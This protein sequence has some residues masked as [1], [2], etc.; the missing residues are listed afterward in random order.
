[1]VNGVGIGGFGGGSLEHPRLWLGAQW[2]GLSPGSAEP[3]RA[4]RRALSRRR[5]RPRALPRGAL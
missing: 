5:S 4:A 3:A 2:A 1:M